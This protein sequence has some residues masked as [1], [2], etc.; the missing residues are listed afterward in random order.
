MGSETWS[1]SGMKLG[2]RE[3]PEKT[4]KNSDTAHQQVVLKGKCLQHWK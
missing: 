3:N 4:P 2:K 1:V